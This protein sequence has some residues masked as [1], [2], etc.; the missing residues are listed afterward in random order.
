MINLT[1]AKNPVF[2]LLA[3]IALL[4]ANTTVSAKEN[5]KL[6]KELLFEKSVELPKPAIDAKIVRVT[7]PPKFKTP[8]H[9]HQ[10]PGP[11][12]ILKGQL[13]VTEGG[14]TNT[15]GAGDVFWESGLRMRVENTGEGEAELIIFELAPS[16]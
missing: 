4:F 7:F 1:T 15:Y 6:N 2:L 12:Y 14:K 5:S 3:T 9:E 11:R 16:Q 8:W 13:T 10:G